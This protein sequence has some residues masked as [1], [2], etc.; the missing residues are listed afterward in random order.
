MIYFC[1]Y[2]SVCICLSAYLKIMM[3]VSL[4]IESIYSNLSVGPQ[5]RLTKGLALKPHRPFKTCDFKH[6][7]SLWS[8]EVSKQFLK[9][10]INRVSEGAV[11]DFESRFICET[12]YLV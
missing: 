4:F 10:P 7:C 6:L 11:F 5:V 8:S 1:F 9:Y 12:W 2:L 3:R